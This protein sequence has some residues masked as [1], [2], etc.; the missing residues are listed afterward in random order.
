M[1]ESHV[2]RLRKRTHNDCLM[3]MRC[4]RAVEV[5]RINGLDEERMHHG[6][7]C[8]SRVCFFLETALHTADLKQ[9][10]KPQKVWL[11]KKQHLLLHFHCQLRLC[12]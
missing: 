12:L 8:S 7:F 5:R 2:I 4:L 11:S 10:Q 3:L 1:A 9:R 6:S